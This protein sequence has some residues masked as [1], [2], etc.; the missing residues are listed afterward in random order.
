ML[1]ILFNLG[2][3]TVYSFGLL[4]ALGLL[5]GVYYVWSHGLDAALPEEKLL[6]RA[7]IVVIAGLLGARLLYVFSN[8]GLY[9]DDWISVLSFWNGGLSFWGA[10][11]GGAV[12]V[13]VIAGRF[14]W[15]A[16]SLFDLAAPALALG[17]SFGYIGALLQGSAYGGETTFAW[18]VRLQGLAGLH[19]PSEIL[20]ALLQL[21]IFFFLLRLRKKAPFGG[22]LAL[23][24][25][26]LYSFGRF[27]L[28]FLRGDQTHLLGPFS[29]AHLLSLV[30]GTTAVALL[31]LRLARLQ[32]SWRVDIRRAI[33]RSN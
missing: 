9:S 33:P 24:Y 7:I 11:L 29:Q 26:I 23:I 20:E 27:V 28:E 8:L 1:P 16:G 31:Y 19:H 12:A 10:I 6:D 14:H 32:G 5:F 3:V 2:P 25:L 18:G 13:R 22:F 21:G 4:L 17:A 30:V 15:P